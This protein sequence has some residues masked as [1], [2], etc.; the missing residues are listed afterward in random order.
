MLDICENEL[1]AKYTT[2]HIGGPARYFIEAKSVNELKE[3]IAFAREKSL[4]MLILGG[5]S[6]MLVSD[7]GFDGV[8][9][10]PKLLGFQIDSEKVTIS[11]SE[12]WDRCAERI[13]EAGLWGVENL[14]FVPGTAAGLAVQNVGAYGQEAA[15]IIDSVETLEIRN[16]K[17]EIRNSR[18]CNFGYRTS[19]FNTT[20]KGRYVILG[21][22]LKLSLDGQS[23]T[24]YG[25][26]PGTL[27]EMREQVIAIRKSKG[28]DPSEFWSAGS[29]FKNPI[30]T[31]K[32]Y[33]AL[34][35]GTPRWPVHE[36]LPTSPSIEGE[37]QVGF[38]KIP[39][40]YL[41]D[42]I[43][44][45]KG[46]TIGGAKL[47]ERQVINIIN[48]GNAT[49]ADVLALFQKARDIVFEKTR[50]TSSGQAGITLE[51][52]PELIGFTDSE[53]RLLLR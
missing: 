2:F 12:N 46:L 33:E 11:A 9:I 50:S 37:E 13:V 27:A 35:S 51:N 41:L 40:G 25:L 49:S 30:I 10:H 8:V 38:L 5:G 26:K 14:S 22:T 15:S 45:L 1:L 17:H 39:A 28:Q 7:R 23:N 24:S 31:E 29:F 18:E 42:K 52:E 3:A 47:S 20:K 6:N 16:S 4:P 53:L 36:P 21:L 48:T 32:Q 44:N 19:I 43:C 34:P